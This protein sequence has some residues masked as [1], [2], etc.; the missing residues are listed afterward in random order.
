M[1]SRYGVWCE[2]D[3]VLKAGRGREAAQRGGSG[4]EIQVRPRRGQ[5]KSGLMS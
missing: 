2:N 3:M 4:V 1:N 5:D